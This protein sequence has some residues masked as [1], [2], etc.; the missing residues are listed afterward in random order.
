VGATDKKNSQ[1]EKDGELFY[2]YE[3]TGAVIQCDTRLATLLL[4]LQL[5]HMRSS[6][7]MTLIEYRPCN[8]GLALL[9]IHHPQERQGVCSLCE[10]ANKGDAA[11]ITC[12]SL[13]ERST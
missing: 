11:C 2:D 3:V 1:H 8:A 13:H 7:D 9:G 5:P 12:S 10:V 4:R 6:Q